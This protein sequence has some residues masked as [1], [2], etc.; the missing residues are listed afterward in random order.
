MVSQPS[1]AWCCGGGRPGASCSHG[2]TQPLI[3]M[4]PRREDVGME[5]L[6]SLSSPAAISAS[7]SGQ[8]NPT[9]GTQAAQPPGVSLLGH[10]EGLR[11]VGIE[12]G[13]GDA[14]ENKQ[15][16]KK[17]RLRSRSSR[18]DRQTK[19]SRGGWRA[20]EGGSEKRLCPCLWAGLRNPN[21]AHVHLLR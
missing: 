4:L 7:A 6:T 5:S 13:A 2:E 10:R 14:V 12:S 21:P 1:E 15:H 9:R 11:R 19:R 3:K 8:L 17:E 16:K 18:R 20:C